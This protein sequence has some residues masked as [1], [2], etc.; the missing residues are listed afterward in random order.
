MKICQAC[1]KFKKRVKI[2]NYIHGAI[3]PLPYIDDMIKP[4]KYLIFE[5]KKY[6]GA[7]G[8]YAWPVVGHLDVWPQI[9]QSHPTPNQ[10]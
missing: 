9:M 10:A 4:H 3:D 7:G 5:G 6:D 8:L 1:E 2:W